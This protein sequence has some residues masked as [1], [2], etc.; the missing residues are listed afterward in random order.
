M[1]SGDLLWCSRCGAYATVRGRGLAEPCKGRHTGHW[2]GGGKRQHLNSLLRNTHP[3]TLAPLPPPIAEGDGGIGPQGS[4]G[5][6][7]RLPA[8]LGCARAPDVGFGA[9][10]PTGSTSSS[11][12]AGAAAAAPSAASIRMQALRERICAKEAAAAAATAA[13]HIGASSKAKRRFWSKTRLD[14]RPA[15][16]G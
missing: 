12:T 7:A 1:L 14:D 10:W 15:A 16:S 13:A 6:Q 4:L 3:V 9:I 11:S 8:A 5:R 2:V